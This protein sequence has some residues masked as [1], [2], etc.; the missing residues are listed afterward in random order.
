MALTRRT[1]IKAGTAAGAVANPALGKA[2]EWVNGQPWPTAKVGNVH[3]LE[4]GKP[5]HFTYPDAQSPAWLVK[6]GQPAYEGVGPDKDIVAFSGLCTHMGCPVAFTGGRFVCPCH[7]SM[8][9]PAKNGQVYQGLATDYLP[10]I[11]LRVDS[12]GDIHAERMEGLVWGR[13]RD[14]QFQKAA[15]K[16]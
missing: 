11:Q 16:A 8:F 12:A 3:Q 9:D 7:K 5:V 6:L 13:V 10:Q 15:S 1:F 2:S 4:P 14:L